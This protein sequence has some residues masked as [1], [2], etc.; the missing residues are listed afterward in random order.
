MWVYPNSMVNKIGVE[1]GGFDLLLAQVA[2]E[3]MDQGAH[4]LQVAKFLSTQRSI[5]NVPFVQ[6]GDEH[7]SVGFQIFSFSTFDKIKKW[8]EA[9]NGKNMENPCFI[10]N[11]ITLRTITLFAMAS[12]RFE[13]TY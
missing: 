9:M 6:F 12:T 13:F 10:E 7:E 8:G 3:L 5:G 11:G 1:T 4:H 2:G